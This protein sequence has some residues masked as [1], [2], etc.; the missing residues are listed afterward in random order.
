MDRVFTP[1]QMAE[2][3]P[4]IP[5]ET[6]RSWRYKGTGPAFFYA[7]KRVFYR[8]AAVLEWEAE[9]EKELAAKRAS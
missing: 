9:Q 3:Y 8:E 5:V 6:F 1:A 7:G 2:R 4:G